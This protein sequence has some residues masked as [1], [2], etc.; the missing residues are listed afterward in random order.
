MGQR[1]LEKLVKAFN[2]GIYQLFSKKLQVL[3]KPK[4]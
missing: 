4:G 1:S 2:M 3:I